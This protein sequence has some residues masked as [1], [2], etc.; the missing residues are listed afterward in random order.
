MAK[1][2]E[3]IAGLKQ[4]NAGAQ[5]TPMELDLTSF[6]SV[7]SVLENASAG[8]G[9]MHTFSSH[10]SKFA[11]DYAERKLS[12]HYLILNA[13]IMAPPRSFTKDGFES[14]I[15]TNHLSEPHRCIVLLL[16]HAPVQVISF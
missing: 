2:E 15:Q 13:G 7:R 9:L 1:L 6:D 5:L 12:L 14:Q 3:A 11:A 16:R 4:A 8:R 10:C